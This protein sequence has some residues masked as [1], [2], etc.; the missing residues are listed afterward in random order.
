VIV[1]LLGVFSAS[2]MLHVEL[3]G[4][5]DH[6]DHACAIT[7]FQQGVESTPAA[8]PLAGAPIARTE[9]RG[10]APLAILPAAPRYWLPP[11]CGPPLG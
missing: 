1:W 8:A 3:H 11:H 9:V 2:P 6:A 7:L 10:A 5:A 4:D